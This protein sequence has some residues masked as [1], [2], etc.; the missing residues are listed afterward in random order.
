[1]WRTEAMSAF[2]I[3]SSTSVEGPLIGGSVVPMETLQR[4]CCAGI[5]RG[6][7]VGGLVRSCRCEVAGSGITLAVCCPDLE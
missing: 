6:P 1:M 4:F 5:E 7:D 3:L 2:S